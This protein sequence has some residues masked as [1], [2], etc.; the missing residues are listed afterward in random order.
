MHNMNS[1]DRILLQKHIREC[2]QCLVL[3]IY[4]WV[5]PSV[6]NRIMGSDHKLIPIKSLPNNLLLGSR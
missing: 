1:Y 5:I 3:C 2:K 4:E 6:L